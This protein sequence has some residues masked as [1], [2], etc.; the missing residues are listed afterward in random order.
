MAGVKVMLVLPPASPESP[1][2]A[3]RSAAVE[4][5]ISLK[6]ALANV[7]VVLVMVRAV[8]RVLERIRIRFVTELPETVFPLISSKFPLSVRVIT[9]E[10]MKSRLS[11]R[12]VVQEDKIIRGINFPAVVSVFVAERVTVL[13]AVGV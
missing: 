9:L 1:V 3:E 2:I 4:R 11:P 6:S 7:P 12:V 13:V 8:P 10:A 5:V